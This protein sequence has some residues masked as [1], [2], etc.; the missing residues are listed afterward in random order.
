VAAAV[1]EAAGTVTRLLA[2][3]GSAPTANAGKEGD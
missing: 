1:P 3:L 2:E